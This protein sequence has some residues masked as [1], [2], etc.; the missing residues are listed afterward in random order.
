MNKFRD[1]VSHNLIYIPLLWISTFM[2][3]V[4]KADKILLII[5]LV[6]AITSLSINRFSIVKYNWNHFPWIKWLLFLTMFGLV[7]DLVHGFGSRELRALETA[8]ILLLFIDI[9][10][11]K[12]SYITYLLLLAAICAFGIAYFYQNID[13]VNR[14][15]WPV[16]AIPFASY[17]SLIITLSALLIRYTKN[18]LQLCILI[19][20][21]CVGLGAL[22]MTESRGPLLALVC[23][24]ILIFIYRLIYS[25]LNWKVL[26]IGGALATLISIFSF[27]YIQERYNNT[28]KEMDLISNGYNQTSIGLRLSLYSTGLELIKE[29][30]ILGYGKDIRSLQLTAMLE[31]KKLTKREYESLNWNFHNGFIEKGVTSGLIG[32]ITMFFWLGMPIVYAW[33]SHREHFTLISAPPLLYFFASLTD[34]P[35]TNG[36]SYVTYLIFTGIILAFLINKKTN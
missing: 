21:S 32:I 12:L 8:T 25:K 11:I 2:F 29:K 7:S 22:I 35:S 1:H 36:S 19:T 23:T 10:K 30:P 31:D 18:I 14:R 20:S 4:E 33:K 27:S 26:F 6:C 28:L 5:V 3:G 17:I 15:T 24:F 13:I 34:T 16:N 9:R